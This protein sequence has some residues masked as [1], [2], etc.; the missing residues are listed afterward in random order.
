[1]SNAF[2]PGFSEAFGFRSPSRAGVTAPAR[3]V[4]DQPLERARFAP[5][6]AANDPLPAEIVAA[7][8]MICHASGDLL[9]R[10]TSLCGA[11]HRP[12]GFDRLTHA[13]ALMAQEARALADASTRIGETI[14]AL[15]A[16]AKS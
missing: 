11:M 3:T 5:L 12:V 9:M 6:V 7:A 16:R 14:L 10:A 1:M 8:N 13:L 15:E 2:Y 4:N